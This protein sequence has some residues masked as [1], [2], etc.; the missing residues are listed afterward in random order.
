M[1]NRDY[2]DMENED[3]DEEEEIFKSM[4]SAS[5]PVLH[6]VKQLESQVKTED[7]YLIFSN[8]FYGLKVLLYKNSI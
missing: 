4:L 3:D 6:T 5:D 1:I 7:E 2:D 8:I